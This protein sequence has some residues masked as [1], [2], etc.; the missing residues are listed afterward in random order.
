[1]DNDNLE[2]VLL[3]YFIYLF[4]VHCQVSV[5]AVQRVEVCKKDEI[6]VALA[7]VSWI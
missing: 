1:M 6:R 2:K 7:L 5:Q 3:F 4:I